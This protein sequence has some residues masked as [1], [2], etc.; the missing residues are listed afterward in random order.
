MASCRPLVDQNLLK[1]ALAAGSVDSAEI[2]QFTRNVRLLVSY[3]TG[4]Y[5][6]LD[7]AQ[8][9]LTAAGVPHAL[10]QILSHSPD[11]EIQVPDR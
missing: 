10:V 3:E 7:Q 2:R 8:T 11:A 6:T 5:G 9:S 1:E 4:E